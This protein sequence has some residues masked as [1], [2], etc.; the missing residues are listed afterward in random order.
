MIN[1]V[2]VFILLFFLVLINAQAFEEDLKEF[3][4]KRQATPEERSSKDIITLKLKEGQPGS[5]LYV[6]PRATAHAFA[7]HLFNKEEFEEIVKFCKVYMESSPEDYMMLYMQAVSLEVLGE[8]DNAIKTYKKVNTLS[9]KGGHKIGLGYFS[10]YG[11]Y[12]YDKADIVKADVQ[13]REFNDW[14]NGVA[15]D[16]KKETLDLLSYIYRAL[17]HFHTDKKRDFDRAIRF[18]DMVLI[19]SPQDINATYN[20][21]VNYINKALRERKPSYF[22]EAE[23][24]LKDTIT[25]DS[26][27]KE[28][29]LARQM[30]KK[31]KETQRDSQE[32]SN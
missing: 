29:E 30:L 17:G 20:L 21:G 5:K 16:A 1:K 8:I 24:L 15:K 25:I 27:S 22:A 7:S 12:K 18:F 13:F 3:L 9:D 14:L 2:A 6:I 32:T 10:L 19:L 31:I 28:A 11:I 23:R 26:V 4:L